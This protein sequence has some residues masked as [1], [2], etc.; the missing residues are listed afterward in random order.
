[1]FNELPKKNK[2]NSKNSNNNKG[3][4][5]AADTENL[6]GENLKPKT[7]LYLICDS[8]RIKH[9]PHTPLSS[10]PS[11]HPSRVGLLLSL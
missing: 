10:S 5:V 4:K 2:K 6:F 7:D 1:M 8:A 11:L 9:A 3:S